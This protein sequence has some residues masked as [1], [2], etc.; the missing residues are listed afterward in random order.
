MKSVG[1][2]CVWHF[3]RSII[4]VS[5]VC[6]SLS[7][8]GTFTVSHH[9][10]FNLNVTYCEWLWA[11]LNMFKSHLTLFPVKWK[12]LPSVWFSD[13]STHFFE[14]SLYIN[15]ISLLWQ[16]LQ[17]LFPSLL[18][19]FGMQIYHNF[20]VL[21]KSLKGFWHYQVIRN[22]SIFPPPRSYMV[23]FLTLQLTLQSGGGQ[24]RW[25]LRV[26]TLPA[27]ETCI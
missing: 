1:S 23:S 17:I 22:S 21:V 5:T 15:E 19:I 13:L 18:L 10:G 14:S 11:S 27:V 16:S 24:W 2:L 20:Y 25:G 6:S 9:S 26:L 4:L 7:L 12:F 3:S 8:G